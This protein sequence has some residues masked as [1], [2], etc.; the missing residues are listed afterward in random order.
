MSRALAAAA[1]L[2]TCIPVIAADSGADAR[3]QGTGKADPIRITNVRRA[4]GPDAGQS[5]ITFD[6]AW[7]HSW[8]AAWE[9]PEEQHGGKGLLKLENWDAAWVFAKFRKP[10]AEGYS[11][12]TLSVNAADHAAPAGAKLEVGPS[13]DGKRGL[14]ASICRAAPGHGAN[15][16]KSVTLR[17]L[18]KA[19][20]VNNLAD[21]EI[22]LLA[23][24]MVYVPQ[25]AFWAG[26]GSKND[27]AQFSAGA[28]TEPLRIESEDAL[29]LGGEN[30]K[31]LGNRDGRTMFRADDFTSF[32]T[33]TVPPKF[34]QGYSAFY[35]L[36]HELTRGEFVAFLNML[37]FEQQRQV[38]GSATGYHPVQKLGPEAPAGTAVIPAGIEDPNAIKVAVPGKSPATPAVYETKAPFLACGHLSWAEGLQYTNWAGL[39]LMTEL[40]YEKACRG[41]LKPVQDEYAWGTN[42]LA[43][44]EPFAKP[45]SGRVA[46]GASYWGIMGLSGDLA[47]RTV[48]VGSRF[49]R[50]FAGTHGA[51]T[52]AP[53][54]PLLDPPEGWHSL[55]TVSFGRRSRKGWGQKAPWPISSRIE[56][57]PEHALNLSSPREHYQD[58]G[59]RCVRTAQ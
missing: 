4:D 15:D 57:T 39:R 44:P 20:G 10:G 59:W 28:T 5:N 30:K 23:L 40:E 47:V 56:A 54:K 43:T 46:A 52:L 16:C 25:C 11:H 29:T 2:L 35:C 51:G 6:L 55:N 27:A 42:E 17:W 18:H 36:K 49:G 9:V 19:D 8:R 31:N 13:D 26:D 34:P 50:R 45:D 37:S 48:T 12:A 58:I 3:F 53:G 33:Q 41:P 1:A 14:G 38:I 7:D 22:K 21:A 32:V 24:K